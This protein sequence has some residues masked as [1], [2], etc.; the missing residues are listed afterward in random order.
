MA[1]L[2][3][4]NVLVYR[5]DPRFP[6]KQRKANALLRTGLV[7]GDARVAHQALVEFVAAA[8]RPMTKARDPLLSRSEALQE[9]EGILNQFPVLYPSAATFRLAIHGVATYGLSWFDANMWAMAEYHSLTPLYTE[10]LHHGATYG[11]VRIVNPF[12]G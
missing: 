3:D 7:Q 8:T 5:F 10:D 9:V 4:T 12:L 2:V 1:H 11:T 6:D